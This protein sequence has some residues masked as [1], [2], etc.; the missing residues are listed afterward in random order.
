MAK[1]IGRLADIGIAKEASR[2]TAESA[3]DFWVPKLSMSYDDGVEQAVDESSVG[4]IEDSPNASVTGKFGVGEIE[5]IVGDKSFGLMLLAALGSVNTTGPAE[6]SV[7]THTFSVGQS[8][9]HPSLTVFLDDGNQD[10]KY[11]LAMLDSLEFEAMIGEY[12][13]F[14]AAF[15]SKAGETATLTP[16]Y[17]VENSFLPQH[18]SVGYA[19]NL[20]G[21]SSPT[22]V[23]VRSVKLSINKNVEDDRKLGS[24]DQADILNRQFAVEGSIELVFDANTFKTEMLADTAKALRIRLTN[25]D[26]TIGSSL[27]PQI[28]IDLAKVKFSEFTKNYENNEIVMATVSFK[29]FYSASDAKMI[30]V[31]LVN[32]QSSY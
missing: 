10:Y 19:D 13:K 3:A 23:N 9:Q 1:F 26:I 29:A 22:T 11:A 18:G 27:N 21:L 12:A 25:S 31:E 5:G 16:S 28:T 7:Y 6:T 8:A 2:G 32:E 30:T 20:A 24:L 15:R 14:T 17:S 4:V